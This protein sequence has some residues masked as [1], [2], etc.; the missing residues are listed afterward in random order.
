MGGNKVV[1]K[2][3]L[4][5]IKRPDDG[6]LEIHGANSLRS[7]GCLKNPCCCKPGWSL[8]IIWRGGDF[9][10]KININNNERFFIDTDGE[11]FYFKGCNE[12]HIVIERCIT[13]L[14]V[15]VGPYWP[16]NGTG[17]PAFWGI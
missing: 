5:N 4:G 7:Y 12:F 9:I 8:P 1:S 10:M 3:I 2:N 6:I 13:P 11:W 16:R 15:V 14:K 17:D